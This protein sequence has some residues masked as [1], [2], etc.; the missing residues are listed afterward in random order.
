MRFARDA[1]AGGV[2]VLEN[3]EWLLLRIDRP[4]GEGECSWLDTGET[5]L[6][7]S[8]PF[9]VSSD[10]GELVSAGTV[11]RLIVEFPM[12]AELGV[13]TAPLDSVS[14]DEIEAPRERLTACGGAACGVRVSEGRPRWLDR[15]AC[16][17]LYT[18]ARQ[19]QLGTV[20]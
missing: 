6:L 15:R 2:I 18:I 1:D 14:S 8:S 17:C 3:D 13:R 12:T 11:S 19:P 20:S 9:L 16:R 5:G 4:A 10:W 7:D